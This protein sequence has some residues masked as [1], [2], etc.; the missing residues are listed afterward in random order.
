MRDETG[1]LVL[2]GNAA[3]TFRRRVQDISDKLDEIA[4]LQD[5]VKDLKKDLKTDGY[6]AKAVNKV[7][8]EM[9]LGPEKMASQLELELVLDTYRHAVGL[10]VDL[11]TAQRLAKEAAGDLPEPEKKKRGK[12]RAMN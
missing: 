3:E 1:R 7:L 12:A 4:E 10:P 8:R 2:G 5:A 9:R 11:E 6:D